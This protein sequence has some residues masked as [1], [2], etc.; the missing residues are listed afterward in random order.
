M[1]NVYF[2]GGFEPKIASVFSYLVFSNHR[3]EQMMYVS[4]DHPQFPRI[5]IT[6]SQ[7]HQ[8]SLSLFKQAGHQ[9]LLE[10]TVGL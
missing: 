10:S 1:V 9:L 2:T 8:A 5:T 6:E 4:M 3:T 7:K